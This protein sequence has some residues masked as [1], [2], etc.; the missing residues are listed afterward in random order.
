MPWAGL[1]L[2]SVLATTMTAFDIW[3]LLMKT[4]EPL[5]M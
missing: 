3:P 4:L 1:A 2:G 5:M